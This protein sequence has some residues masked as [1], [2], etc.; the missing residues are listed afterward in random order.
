VTTEEPAP[1]RQAVVTCR[2][3]G[4]SNGTIPITV[5][6][7]DVPDPFVICGVCGQPI[8]DITQP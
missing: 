3:A 6:V 7:P 1:T 8:T 4:C 2:T 5:I